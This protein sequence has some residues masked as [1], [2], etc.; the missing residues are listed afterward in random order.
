VFASLESYNAVTMFSDAGPNQAKLVDFIEMGGTAAVGHCFEPELSA[1]IL[2]EFLLQNLLRDDD[3]DGIGDLTLVE[4][5]FTALPYLSWS[6]VMI[7]DPLM[8][9]REGPGGLVSTEPCHGDINSDGRING[10]D[11]LALFNTWGSL[12]GDPR[13]CP[14]SD[15]NQDGFVGSQDLANVVIPFNTFCP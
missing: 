1:T 7:G 8:R 15:T 6:E 11:F 9:L 14:T 2:G 10:S 3:E 4:A 13:Y 12:I 5:V